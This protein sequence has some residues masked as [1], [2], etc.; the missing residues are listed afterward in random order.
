M[1]AALSLCAALGVLPAR[2]QP[3]PND[4]QPQTSTQDLA[5]ELARVI[6]LPTPAARAAAVPE[7][8][9]ITDELERW[10]EVCRAFGAFAA[11]QPGLM[12][13]KLDLQ[14][15]DQ[16]ERTDTFLYVPKG[17]DPTKPAPLLYFGHGSHGSG[18]R[19]H[20]L[21]RAVADQAGL[22]VLAT[23]ESVE[24]VYAKTPRERA[25]VLAALRWARRVA[26]VDENAVFVGGWSRGGHLAWDLALRHPD[27]FAGVVPCVG[28]P[29]V[30]LGPG[31]NIRYLEN[32]TS[33]AIRDLQGSGDDPLLLRNLHI[34]F[35]KLKKWK[36][37]D[38]ELIEFEQLGHSAD[39]SA[40]EWPAFFAKR[41]EPW[42]KT[43]VRCAAVEG[44]ARAAWLQITRFTRKVQ[45]A[46]QPSVAASTWNRLDDEGRTRLL[47]DKMADVTARLEVKDRGNGK[48]VADGHGIAAF[49]LLLRED[50]LGKGGK[51]EVR[52]A[53]KPVRKQVTPSAEVL[54]R[55]F[56]E[57]FDR[58]RLPVARVDVP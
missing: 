56:V 24:G 41:R 57:R 34:A 8:L 52:V 51:V 44:E 17:Y 47:V 10:H 29:R 21:W 43:V 40:V 27:L 38:A 26:N 4:Q 12:S 18:E 16:V 49:S 14:V 32:V 42:P 39:L 22:L 37:K 58:S 7:L 31:G 23:T 11:L 1:L 36:A 2:Q 46:A 50:Q 53:R 28:G 54:L 19:Q 3:A 6:D 25:A 33:L 55:D 45:E 5:G 35:D 30:E 48:F 20:E 9:A 13:E 15:L